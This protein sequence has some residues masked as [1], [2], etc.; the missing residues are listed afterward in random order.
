MTGARRIL[1]VQNGFLFGE[2]E[3]KVYLIPIVTPTPKLRST[4]KSESGQSKMRAAGFLPC[5]RLVFFCGHGI[6]ERAVQKLCPTRI[7]D[8]ANR[9]SASM[10]KKKRL[11]THYSSGS[12]KSEI[13][14]ASGKIQKI[15]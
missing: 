13:G 6:R 8:K 7:K 4:P 3:S 15:F 10:R 5:F 12:I 14:L 11:A 1:T 2:T 9:N